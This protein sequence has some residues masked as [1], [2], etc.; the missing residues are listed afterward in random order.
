MKIELHVPQGIYEKGRRLKQEDAIYPQLSKV[1]ASSR[2]FVVCDG[3]GGHD[4]GEVA[5]AVVSQCVGSLVEERMSA[6]EPLSKQ[7]IDEVVA[8]AHKRLNETSERFGNTMKPMGT[9]MVLLA[10]GDNGVVAAHIGDSRIYHVRPATREILYR[11]R[12]HSLVNDLFAMGRLTRAE[13]QASPKKNVLTRAM[14]APP[15]P[16]EKADVAFITD[17]KAGDYFLLC[18]DGVSGEITDKKLL[19]ALCNTTLSDPLKIAAIKVMA[20][21]GADN[22][23]ALLMPVA[24]VEHDEGEILLT[25]NE[26]AMC[27]KMVTRS[28]MGIAAAVPAVQSNDPDDKYESFVDEH[29]PE[30]VK[31]PE[32]NIPEIPVEQTEPT[33][34]EAVDQIEPTA[35]EDLTTEVAAEPTEIP[36]EAPAANLAENQ[37]KNLTKRLGMIVLAAL[38]LAGVVTAFVMLLKPGD[39]KTEQP[40]VADSVVVDNDVTIDTILPESPVDTMMPTGSNVPVPPAPRVT[41]VPLPSY[42]T[43]SNV[44]VP[45]VKEG[46]PYPSAFNDDDDYK[47]LEKEVPATPEP[48]PQAKSTAEAKA[49]AGKQAVPGAVPSR[50]S[51]GASNRSVAVPPPPGKRRPVQA[52]Y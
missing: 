32:D 3:L 13:A 33:T 49:Q 18:S 50:Q 28:T 41:D 35:E 24:A 27:D 43:G 46:D 19:N 12:D 51:V 9:T 23:T 30:E 11:S 40:K 29:V 37:K 15:F 20:Q 21:D 7:M 45:R 14:I 8:E 6:G 34:I 22:R 17:V 25:D 1:S 47:E 26:K 42:P 4:Y 44:K 16:Q 39:K 10:F 36:V 2:V 5:S 48:E 38:L 31:Q 52:P